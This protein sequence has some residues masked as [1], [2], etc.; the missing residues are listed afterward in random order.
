MFA[1]FHPTQKLI[2]A[3]FI[4]TGKQLARTERIEFDPVLLT[5]EQRA[6][7]VRCVKNECYEM[8][9][10]TTGARQMYSTTGAPQWITERADEFETLPSIADWIA[11]AGNALAS[12]EMHQAEFDR[13]AALHRE[14][15][16]VS[17]QAHIDGIAA[18]YRALIE[19]RSATYTG[20]NIDRQMAN[21]RE[22]G[23]E[24]DLRAYEAARAEYLALQPA[25]KAEAEARKAAEA[26]EKEAAKQAARDA[27]IA[28][29][30]E[31]GSERLR[32]GMAAGHE[33]GRLYFI[34]RAAAEFPGY[35]L[36]YEDAAEWKDRVCPSIEALNERDAVLLAHPNLEP[37]RVKIVWL[38]KAASDSPT[39][40]GYEEEI[41]PCEAVA[42][43]SPEYMQWLVRAL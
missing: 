4:A 34:E 21:A 32:R 39:D 24:I 12:R 13:L 42:V 27:R 40:E 30:N 33:C 22:A 16:R 17:A 6:V 29:A 43:D 2:S 1:E 15:V 3:H 36:D 18:N 23:A 7:L 25:F 38:V 10:R 26:A 14:Q 5:P 37:D 8:P 41:E 9:A 19:A 35:V 11:R 20:G 28:W 31:H